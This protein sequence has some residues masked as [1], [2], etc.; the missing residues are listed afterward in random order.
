MAV[1]LVCGVTGHLKAA[2]PHITVAAGG[3]VTGADDITH[4]YDG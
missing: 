3:R 4:G 2:C 1:A